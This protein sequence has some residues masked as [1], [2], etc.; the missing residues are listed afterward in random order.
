MK[1]NFKE[2]TLPRFNFK[3]LEYGLS[4]LSQK[5]NILKEQMY[6]YIREEMIIGIYV[7][8]A[9]LEKQ[10]TYQIDVLELKMR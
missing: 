5:R 9:G 10:F 4:Q 2:D 8:R 3:E 1:L 7:H 6:K